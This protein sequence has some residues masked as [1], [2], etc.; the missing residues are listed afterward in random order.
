[1]TGDGG[2]VTIDFSALIAASVPDSVTAISSRER[3]AAQSCPIW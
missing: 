2:Q 3:S 1:M